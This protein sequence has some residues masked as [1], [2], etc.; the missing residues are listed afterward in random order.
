MNHQM[1]LHP[2]SLKFSGESSHLE[3]PFLKDY[4]KVSLSHVRI[5]L[6]LGAVLYG[7][8]GV[9]DALVMPEQMY[10]IWLV[11]FVVIGPGLVGVL[12]LSFSGLFEK[13]MQPILAFA[14]ILAGLGIICMIVIAPP[15]VSYA[16]YA[17]LMLVFMWG[18]AL[19]RLFFVW[20]SFAGWLQ[21]L[22]YELTAIW[23]NQTPFDIFI[24]NN[25]FFM[26]ANVIGM[27]A[28]YLIEFYARRD[29]FMKRQL[30]KERENVN[31]INEELEDRVRQRT[32]DYQVVNLALQQEIAGH[33]KAKEDLHL[34][35]DSLKKAV[36]ATIHVMA[37]AVEAR[38]PYT[39]GHQIRSAILACA[40][41]EEMGLSQEQIEGIRM[42]GSIHDIGKLSIPAEILTKPTKLT[43]LEFSLIK[44]HSLSGN[45]MLKDVES[46]WPLAEIVYQHHERIDGSG[47]P[48]KLKGDDIL[49]EARIL[50]VSDVVESMASHRPYRPS[51]GIKAALEEIEK[52]KG[53]LYDKTVADTCLQLFREK[54]YK[55]P[56]DIDNNKTS[57]KQ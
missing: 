42:A 9:L 20:A 55:L 34:T 31:R 4:Y 11:R 33:K 26:G 8:F 17:G 53:I 40:I 49:I 56:S 39:A 57:D 52:N 13:Y 23:I 10:A 32:E 6:V 15:P 48:R 18:Y 24:S 44:E 35:L 45:E 16:Y 22:L 37:S 36:G 46:P 3:E 43:N 1:K 51:L 27:I 29:F 38:D 19:I 28:C 12:L 54:K 25:F 14:Y 21:V 47:Y 30:E 5:L 2:L 41:A 50:A 7:A